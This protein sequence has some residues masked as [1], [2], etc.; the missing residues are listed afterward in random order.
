MSKWGYFT[1][2]VGAMAITITPFTAGFLGTPRKSGFGIWA[3]YSP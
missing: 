3:L 1:L 2:L